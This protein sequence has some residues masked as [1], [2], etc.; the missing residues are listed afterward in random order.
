MGSF[1]PII[2]ILPV[3]TVLSVAAERVT[4][5]VKLRQEAA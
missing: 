3:L 4:N 1:E 2:N 5:F